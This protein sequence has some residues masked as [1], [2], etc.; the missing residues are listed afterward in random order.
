MRFLL[1]TRTAFADKIKYL[2][3][4]VCGVFMARLLLILMLMTTQLLT[5]SGAS[6][7]LCVGSNGS[8]CFDS[9]PDSCSCC[10]EEH[11]TTGDGCKHEHDDAACNHHDESQPVQPGTDRLT[12]L[13]PCGCTHIPV[14]LPSDQPTNASRAAVK[15]DVERLTALIT[16]PLLSS[17][18]G[19]LAS[20][21]AIHWSDPPPDGNFALTIVSTVVIRC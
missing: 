12:A 9:G 14:M 5:G 15:V 19:W 6:V 13:D 7:Y 1:W 17:F 18:D 2:A 20:Q 4:S 8:Y 16:L 3:K 10:H 21:P 11:E